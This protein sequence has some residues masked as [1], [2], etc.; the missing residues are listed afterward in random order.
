MAERARL[1][2]S[3]PKRA[4]DTPAHAV[5]W[6][7]VRASQLAVGE[8]RMEGESYLSSGYGI[9]QLIESKSH[10]WSKLSEVATVSQPNRLKGVL[11]SKEHGAPFLSAGQLFDFRPVPRKWLAIEKTKAAKSYFVD[12]GT[13]L[14]TRSGSVGQSTL[15]FA[16]HREVIVSDDL[17]RVISKANDRHGWVYAY[18]KA[19]QVRAMTVNAHYG[20]IIKHLEVSHLNELPIP[21][22]DDATASQFADQIDEV[23]RL[24]N[25]SFRLTLAAEK[26]FSDALGPVPAI[27]GSENGFGVSASSFASRRRRFDAANHHPKVSAIWRQLQERGN[28]FVSIADAGYDVWLPSRFKR[29]PASEGVQLWDSAALV[30]VNPE[31]TKRIA[32]GDFGDPFRGRVEAGWVLMARSG[33]VYGI[34]GTPVLASAAMQGH[35]VSDHVMRFRPRADAEIAAGY[36]VTALSHPELGRPLV[37]ALAYGSSIPEIEVADMQ[38]F[39]VVRLG[40]DVE[41]AIASAA[42]ASAK[43]RGEADLIEQDMADR[44]GKIVDEFMRRPSLQVATRAE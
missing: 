29:I 8:R 23:V 36:L 9:R 35:V 42:E 20:Q 44:A 26:L 32:D 24:R 31:A 2:L 15:A 43:A 33:Q 4:N 39:E 12:E 6:V 30:E 25:E 21:E 1:I 34:I 41:A 38:R 13:I 7:S 22:V 17:L 3:A 40:A 19:P 16:P 28:G 37:K 11:V 10:G 14:V 18:L 27:S 5:R